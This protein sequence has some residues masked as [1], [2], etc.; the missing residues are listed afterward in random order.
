[1]TQ[2]AQPPESREQQILFPCK[3]DDAVPA[4]HVVRMLDEIL[5]RLDWSSWEGRYHAHLGQPAIHPRVLAALLLY[6]LLNRIRSSRQLERAAQMQLD[7]RWL[8]QGHTPDYT[9]LSEFRRKFGDELRQLFVQIGLVARELG[10]LALERL[11]FDGTRVKAN[12]RRSGTR[13]PAELRK[14]RD[15]LAAKFADWERQ[16]AEDDSRQQAWLDEAGS[17]RQLPPELAAA[18]QRIEEIDAALAKLAELEAAG[19]KVPA[20]LPITDLESRLMPNKEGGFAPNYTPTATV[21]VDS[22]LIVGCDVLDEVSEEH[23]LLPAV[24]EVRQDFGV[25]PKAVMADGLFETG[26]NLVGLEERQITFYSPSSRGDPAAN[27]ALRD[28]LAQPV[29]ADKLALLPMQVISSKQKTQQFAKSVFVYDAAQDVY[30]CPNGKRLAYRNTTPDRRQQ[31]QA[32]RRRYLSA[33]EDCA[34]CPLRNRCLQ[35]QSSQRSVSRDQYESHRERHARHMAQADS[36]ASYKLRRHAGETPFAWIKQRLGLRQFS[37]RGLQ[38]V[39]VEWR[40]A[41][42][43]FNLARV[44]QLFAAQEARAGP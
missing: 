20:R 36:Q 5:G 18:A 11:A 39:R 12:N 38:R 44:L 21:D 13:T 31:G 8:A 1:M 22:G 32:Q 7:F 3:L 37:L 29:A 40:W 28:D 41:A 14:L 15:E 25:Q 34:A 9:T 35:A 6:G 4:G 24:D 26:P 10:C 43:A 23:E 16:T 42:T 2:W 17:P 27:P 33:A 30:W 19:L